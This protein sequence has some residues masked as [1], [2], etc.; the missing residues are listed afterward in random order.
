MRVALQLDVHDQDLGGGERHHPGTHGR[1]SAGL[2][3]GQLPDDGQDEGSA[4]D[5][6]QDHEEQHAVA[7]AH[8]RGGGVPDGASVVAMPGPSFARSAGSYPLSRRA[9]AKAETRQA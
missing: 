4:R 1:A 7:R 6:E 5:G 3:A 2:G 9:A 8:P